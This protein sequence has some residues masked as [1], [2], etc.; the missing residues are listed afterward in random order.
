MRPDA[1]APN[2]DMPVVRSSRRDRLILL[3]IAMDASFGCFR[4]A[5]TAARF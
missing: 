2:A 4:G 5:Q 3:A 1:P